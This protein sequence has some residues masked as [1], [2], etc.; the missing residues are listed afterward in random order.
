MARKNGKFQKKR[1]IPL[2][3]WILLAVVIL[4][5]SAGSVV[6]WLSI[7]GGQVENSFTPDDNLNPTIT[8]TF[9]END[10]KLK[11]NVVVRVG[12]TGYAVYVRAAIVVNWKNAEDG[13]VLGQTPVLDGDYT[14]TLNETDWF[15]KDGFYYH[16]AMVNTGGTTANL[17]T[18][19]QLKEGITPPV[20][21]TVTPNV[22]YDLN[23]EIIAQTIQALGTTDTGDTPAVTDAWGVTVTNKQLAP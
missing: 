15:Y 13:N 17:I 16:K 6:A 10:D 14:L 3:S 22:K 20:D 11:Q 5:L 4:S 2:I 7:P 1:R 23:V 9:K 18:S 21:T 19:C 8:E 12:D